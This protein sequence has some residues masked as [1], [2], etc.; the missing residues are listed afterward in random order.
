M[1]QSFRRAR[2]INVSRQAKIFRWLGPTRPRTPTT[3]ATSVEDRKKTLTAIPRIARPPIPRASS[4]SHWGVEM[5]RKGGVPKDRVLNCLSKDELAS[6]WRR[7]RARR[8]IKPVL[9]HRKRWSA[10]FR[11]RPEKRA[12]PCKNRKVAVR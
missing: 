7:E 3:N 8:R 12:A 4:I 2:T 10:D 9:F 11:R 1:W 6:I 5:A